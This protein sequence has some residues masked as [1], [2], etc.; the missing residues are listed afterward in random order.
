MVS[1]PWVESLRNQ[2]G[3]DIVSVEDKSLDEH[4]RDRWPVAIKQHQQNKRLYRPEAIVSPRTTEDVSRVLKWANEWKVPVTP[5]GAGS[6]VTGAPLS[7]QGGITLNMARMKRIISVDEANL[8]ATVEAGVMG[9]ELEARLN[10]GGYTLHHSPQSLALSTVGG[11]VATLATGQFSSR[12]GGIEGLVVAVKVVLPDGE[13][14]ETKL[15]PRAAIG[16]DLK[17]LFL[18]SEGTLGVIT[19]VSMKI[20]PLSAYQVVEAFGFD[21]IEAGLISIQK[22][23]RS[24]LQPFLVRLYDAD[25]SRHVLRGVESIP[26]CLLFVGFEG[27]HSVAGA[28]H[29]AAREMCLSEGGHSLGPSPVLAWI[30]RRFDFSAVESVLEQPGGFAET[31]EIAHFWSEILPTYHR[32]KDALHPYASEVLGH[33]SH[34]YLQGTSL[35]LILLGQADSPAEAEERLMDIWDVAMTLCLECGAAITH[36]HGV[37]LARAPYIRQELSTS[38]TLLERLKSALDPAQI[39]NPGKLG[40]RV[41]PK[42]DGYID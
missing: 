20:F 19:E 15:T 35:Y 1:A 8:F 34:V 37:G 9:H 36:H 31:I 41:N 7:V 2:I 27:I 23:L 10:S 12:W 25:E 32:L 14:I 22:I 40:L 39:M 16:P 3:S 29:S 4:S 28:E 6:S 30:G 33:F 13:I 17:H 5:W 24:G 26:A 21:T 38:M 18:G 11:W 42:Q